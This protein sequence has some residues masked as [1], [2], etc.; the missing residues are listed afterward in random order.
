MSELVIGKKYRD[1]WG[2]VFEIGG[3]TR[4]YPLWVWSI[5]GTW[6]RKSDGRKI[7]YDGKRGHYPIDRPTHWDLHV[8]RNSD[9]IPSPVERGVRIVKEC[10]VCGFE[11]PKE[12]S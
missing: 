5:Q 8:C 6:F 3:P 1:G 12:E 7:Q 11:N 10:I 9:P 4:D 2:T